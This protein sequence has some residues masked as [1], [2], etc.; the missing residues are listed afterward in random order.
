M[1][2]KTNTE[3]RYILQEIWHFIIHLRWHYQLF[4]LSGGFL[5][6]GLLS[7]TINWAYFGIQFLNVHLLLF[8]GATAYNSYWDKDE[9]PVGGLKNPPKMSPW[10]WGAS[11]LL[12]AAGLGI[13]LWHGVLFAVIY[14]VSFVLFWLYSTPHF[15]WKGTP[16]KSLVAIGISTGSNS[17][18]MGYLAAGGG[19]R[20]FEVWNAA[21]GVALMVLSLYPISQ[22][23][24]LDEDIRRGDQTFAIQFGFAGVIQFFVVA[25]AGGMMLVGFSLMHIQRWF[26]VIFLLIGIITGIWIYRQLKNI[27]LEKNDYQTVMRI[28]YATSLAFVFFLVLML[29]AKHSGIGLI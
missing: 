5:L 28:K 4:I 1:M 27:G 9:G 11:I 2:N 6:G 14:L 19:T 7:N 26:G 12:Q 17:V 23:Y 21:L 20:D 18:L 16:L 10:M 29:V 13:A 25:F 15:R 3:N 24:Q 22:L 8:G